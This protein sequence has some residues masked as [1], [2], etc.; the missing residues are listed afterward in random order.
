MDQD[1]FNY[2]FRTILAQNRACFVQNHDQEKKPYRNINLNPFE[3]LVFSEELNTNYIVE[4]V[5][6]EYPKMEKKGQ[7]F[8]PNYEIRGRISTKKDSRTQLEHTIIWQ[9]IFQKSFK[10]I[11]LFLYIFADYS[12]EKEFKSRVG[13]DA[14]YF[15]MSVDY[16]FYEKKKIYCAL[17]ACSAKD[18][19]EYINTNELPDTELEISKED[20]PKYLKNPVEFIPELKTKEKG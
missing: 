14:Y 16:T 8:S 17:L 4:I 1:Y 7:I 2:V 9:N 15:E 18:Y 10:S 19:L 11:L 12:A 13:D 5:G 3:F 20:A 6:N